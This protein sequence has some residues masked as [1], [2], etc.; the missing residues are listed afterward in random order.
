MKPH[1]EPDDE[2]REYL[3]KVRFRKPAHNVTGIRPGLCECP[4]PLTLERDG[5]VLCGRCERV[6]RPRVLR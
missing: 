5:A 1:H 2:H 4:R 6:V 3:R